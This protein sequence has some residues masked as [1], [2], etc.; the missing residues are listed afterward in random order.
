MSL[1]PPL[2]DRLREVRTR[3]ATA[4]ADLDRVLAAAQRGKRDLTPAETGK[5]DALVG[6]IRGLDDEIEKVDTRIKELEVQEQREA[7]AAAARVETGHVGLQYAY[8]G[9]PSVYHP[10]PDSPSFFRDLYAAR[11]GNWAAAERLHRNN[12]QVGVERR[13][14]STASGAGGEFAPPAWLIEEFVALARPGRVLADR[15]TREPLPTGVSSINLPRVATGTTTAVQATQ[16]TAVSQTDITTDA[17]SSGITTIAGKQVI[18]LQLLEQSGIPFDRVILQDLAADYA[19]ELDLQ[20]I[21]GSGASGQLEGVLTLA[22]TNGVTYTSASPAVT[23]T[24]AADSFLGQILTAANDI[25]TG[26]FRAPDAIV[27]H[28]RR[29]SWVL[30]ALDS[31]NR[32]LVTPDGPAFNQPAVSTTPTAQ[33]AAGTLAGIPVFVDPNMPTNHGAGTNQDPVIVAKFDEC[34]L[35]ESDL[36]AETFDA[37]YADSMGILFRVYAYSAFIPGRRPKAISVIDGTGLVTPTL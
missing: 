20:V 25:Y 6:E 9:D 36:K 19:K 32:P 24:T 13:A 30:N 18:S 22:G 37:P 15:C 11:R 34:H 2:E 3:R 28:P 35:W 21:A 14:L 1:I 7:A 29:W 5:F 33:G 31:T 17:V 27:M 23:S 26:I 16:N 12:A 4:K 8:V 10:G